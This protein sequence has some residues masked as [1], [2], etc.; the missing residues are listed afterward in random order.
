[1]ESFRGLGRHFD[2]IPAA[3]NRQLSEIDIA[4]GRQEAAHLSPA[5]I[6]AIQAHVDERWELLAGLESRGREPALVA[7]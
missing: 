5:E 1:M 2:L 3:I 4:R 6:A 7:R